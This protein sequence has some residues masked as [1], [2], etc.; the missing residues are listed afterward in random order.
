MRHPHSIGKPALGPLI[1]VLGRGVAWLDMG[2]QEAL[3]Q[4]AN[5]VQAVE[6]RQGMMIS[7]PEEIAHRMGYIDKDQLVRLSEE[8]ENTTYGRYLSQIVDGYDVPI[9]N[10]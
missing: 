3:L 8:L 9:N 7:C 5:F 10:I 1:K 2:T 6:E 4:A